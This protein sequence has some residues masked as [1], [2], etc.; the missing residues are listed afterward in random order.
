MMKAIFEEAKKIGVE[1]VRLEVFS[2][3]EHAVKTYKNFGFKTFGK[4]PKG[5]LKNGKYADE[6]YMYKNI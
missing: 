4:L 6:I 3:N 1:V 2:N 5:I